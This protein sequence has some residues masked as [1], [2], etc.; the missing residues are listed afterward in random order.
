MTASAVL[1][2][3]G[4][5]I[6]RS[7]PILSDINWRVNPGENWGILGPNGCGKT[8]LLSAVTGYLTPTSGDMR[9]LGCTYG[10][11]DWRELRKRIGIVS[12][13]LN[14][15]IEYNETALDAV[16]SGPAAVINTWK[17]AAPKTR[18]EAA[19]LLR[20]WQCS[21]LADRPWGV[22]SQGE[23]QRV[24]I[25]RAL[26]AAP[27]LLLLDE[28]CAGLDPVAREKLLHLIEKQ[29]ARRAGPAIVFITHHVE[30]ITPAFTHVLL[31]RK[32]S[33]HAAG[34]V[35]ATLTSK[36]LSATFGAHVSV[37]KR[38]GRWRLLL[39]GS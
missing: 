20:S 6:R 34:P 30:E 32:G 1:D 38:A 25:A 35:D 23:R 8:S 5:N 22:L 39:A 19:R 11:S 2:V 4:L 16:A 27:P 15:K 36:N 17:P 31:L 10:R 13:T 7:V 3:R 12:N 28:P 18:A 14:R 29:A 37:R 24:L 26:L 33:V 21:K 9:V